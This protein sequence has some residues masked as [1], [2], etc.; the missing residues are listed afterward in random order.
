[1]ITG[2]FLDLAVISVKDLMTLLATFVCTASNQ[3][4]HEIPPSSHPPTNF[5]MDRSGP[6]T[7]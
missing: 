4:Y 6:G 5:C 1:M 3:I 2:V 7:W